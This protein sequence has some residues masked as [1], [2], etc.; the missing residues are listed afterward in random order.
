MPDSPSAQGLTPEQA[1]DRLEELHS[2]ASNALRGALARYTKSGVV[3]T[4]EERRAFRYPELC[5][6]WQPAG[7]V[8]FTRRAWAKF[9]SPGR[10]ATTVTQPGF[11]RQYLL[12][13][14]RPLAEEFGARI[15]VAPSTQ[16]IPYPFVTEE[17][18]EFVH[19]DL[20][21]ADLARHFPTP[22][23]A[24]VGDEVVDGT[25]MFQDGEPRPLA[26]FDA[27]RVD[28]SLRRLI[29]Y[30]GCDWRTL[31]PWILFTNYQRYIDQFLEWALEELGRP[32]GV[33]TALALPGGAVVRRG[34]DTKAVTSLL[35]AAPWHRFQMPAYS[36]MRSDA[37][38]GITIVNIGVGP[39]NAKNATDH[40]A[41]LRPHCWLTIG[42]CG[43]LRQSQ[44]IGDYVLA[45][46]YLR[47]D[48]ILD[49]LVPPEM[50]IPALAE[51]QQALQ[52]AAARVTGE[53]GDALKRRLRTGTV[54]SYDD[55]NWEL[56]W[57]QER[58]RISLGRAIAVDMESA[59]LATQGYRLR[60]PYGTLLCVSD[61]PLHGEIKLP[62]AATRF[63]QRA[64]GEHLRIGLETVN[65]L[66]SE[67][68]TL[69]SRKL[70]SFDEPPFR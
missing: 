56:R 16:E 42:H 2:A 25:W 33:Y 43:G 27:V 45:H 69:H 6:D 32:G 23:L 22:M 17:G 53:R 54:V 14:L 49:D 4:A 20:A 38:G 40:L 9:Q 30:T 50:P 31:Q 18:D 19:G 5:I 67:L 15:E 35:A 11:F 37:E 12:E 58:Q 52:E 51:V 3:P 8:R 24:N 13:Q 66:R 64:V 47:R 60:V 48:R 59:T 57:S 55:R 46:G 34:G 39:S 1:V 26:L 41:V 61:K 7:A 65:L 70:R 29:H 21:V 68:G 44:T 36:L 63:Y 28:F 62:G 10:Y